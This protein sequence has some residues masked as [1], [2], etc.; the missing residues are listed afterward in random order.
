MQPESAP[1]GRRASKHVTRLQPLAS[2]VSFR[3]AFPQI[4]VHT[5][6]TCSWSTLR[7]CVPKNFAG[8]VSEHGGQG[9]CLVEVP[10]RKQ[11]RH[12]LARDLSPGLD[13]T[14]AIDM[15]RGRLARRLRACT[16]IWHRRRVASLRLSHALCLEL[17][18]GLC[19]CLCHILFH[20]CCAV[21]IEDR[22]RW[23]RH[24][25]C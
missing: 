23:P 14:G 19:L 8:G 9:S 12:H 5:G 17:C 13:A 21:Q 4:L 1:L 10:P 7:H 11:A 15:V 6:P 20:A 24:R 22:R 16:A 2:L 18:L 3:L 25:L